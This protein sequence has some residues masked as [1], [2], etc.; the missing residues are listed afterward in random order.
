MINEKKK[1]IKRGRKRIQSILFSDWLNS[2]IR[3]SK[4]YSEKKQHWCMLKRNNCINN[5]AHFIAN[6]SICD[7]KK[8]KSIKQISGYIEELYFK[9]HESICQHYTDSIIYIEDYI[10]SLKCKNKKNIKFK[11]TRGD[12]LALIKFSSDELY[13]TQ[14]LGHSCFKRSVYEYGLYTSNK[15]IIDYSCKLGEIMFFKDVYKVSRNLGLNIKVVSKINRLVKSVDMTSK[16]FNVIR[17]SKDSTDKCFILIIE[18]KE[19][20]HSVFVS[21]KYSEDIVDKVV[22]KINDSIIDYNVSDYYIKV[23]GKNEKK[24]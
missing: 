20:M 6:I 5:K 12:A 23:F 2:I 4:K 18:L 17:I 10:Y 22:D 1:E 8:N 7:E 21:Q 14:E 16:K 13:V 19:L 15:Y 11:S 9:F 24:I 3:S